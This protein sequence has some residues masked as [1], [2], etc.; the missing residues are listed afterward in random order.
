M[1]VLLILIVFLVLAVLGVSLVF[2]LI[3]SASSKQQGSLPGCGKCGYPAQGISTLNCPECGADLRHVGIVNPG[4]RNVLGIGCLLVP[5]FSVAMFLIA[6]ILLGF[7]LNQVLP[8]RNNSI[9]GVWLTPISGELQRIDLSIHYNET[10]PANSSSFN[11]AS[12]NTMSSYS[13]SGSSQSSSLTL[14][15]QTQNT[16]AASFELERIEL[17]LWPKSSVGFNWMTPLVEL[18][19]A[20]GDVTWTDHKGKTHPPKSNFT[21]QDMLAVLKDIGADTTKPEVVAEAKDLNSMM[22]AMASTPGS[23]ISNAFSS[24]SSSSSSTATSDPPWFIA[25]Y[26]GTW[27]A[28][29]IVG[30]IF[31]ARWLRKGRS[32]TPKQN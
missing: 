28:L 5:S 30:L 24:N 26:A 2:G 23:H 22:K 31:I 21:D 18:D 6:A 1:S 13:T 10:F 32:G 27:I 19:P 17:E 20:T 4:Q 11:S 15:F 29:W 3:R 7:L 16:S 14:D 12:L 25:A 8:Q 9:A